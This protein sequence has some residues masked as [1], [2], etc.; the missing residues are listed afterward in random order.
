MGLA[1]LSSEFLFL[2]S[3]SPAGMDMLIGSPILARRPADQGLLNCSLHVYCDH[4]KWLSYIRLSCGK[5]YS[6]F[7][8]QSTFGSDAEYVV[9]I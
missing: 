9:E 2:D 1:G 8:L 5:V 3:V 7:A 6:I 4:W